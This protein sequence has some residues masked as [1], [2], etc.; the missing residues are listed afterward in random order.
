MAP[1]LK[2]KFPIAMYDLNDPLGK[3]YS[4]E[5]ILKMVNL[6]FKHTRRKCKCYVVFGF[7]PKRESIEFE[8][9][10]YETGE[11]SI[12]RVVPLG[13]AERKQFDNELER[14]AQEFTLLLV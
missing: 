10:S 4:E 14:L 1:G 12:F 6:C 8:F 3:T 2:P 13:A 7:D 5:N 9:C 11:V